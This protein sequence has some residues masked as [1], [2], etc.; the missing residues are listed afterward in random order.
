MIRQEPL[1]GKGV[2]LYPNALEHIL[3][4]NGQYKGEDDL[5]KLM[6]D[7]LCNDPDD[8]NFDILADRTRY[9][10][11]NPEGVSEMCK[12]MEDMRN[13]ALERGRVEV[14]VEGRLNNMLES[15]RSLKAKL[16]LSDQQVKDA[17]SISNEDWEKIAVRV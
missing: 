5:G 6:H 16:G 11:E 8:M 13:E 2:G 3:Y 15:V 12:A 14:L 10:K 1:S 7:F 4:V 9:F 17:L